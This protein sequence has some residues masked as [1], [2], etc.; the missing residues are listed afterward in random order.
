MPPAAFV[1]E[2][3][4]HQLEAQHLQA[5]SSERGLKP[6]TPSIRQGVGDV[7]GPLRWKRAK[8]RRGSRRLTSSRTKKPDIRQQL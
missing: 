3:F 8:T 7:W 4:Y 2:C 6:N 5:S 1:S